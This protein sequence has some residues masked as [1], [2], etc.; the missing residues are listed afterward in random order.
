MLV[1]KPNKHHRKIIHL[2]KNQ[3]AGKFRLNGAEEQF[4]RCKMGFLCTP[5]S[6]FCHPAACIFL[7]KIIRKQI[8]IAT[9]I[10]SIPG[11]MNRFS[12]TNGKGYFLNYLTLQQM[13]RS[14]TRL[15]RLCFSS[16]RRPG[17]RYF[18][19]KKFQKPVND[20]QEKALFF[21]VFKDEA[22]SATG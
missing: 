18:T 21:L 19:Q 5:G 22:Y 10:S 4:D 7:S 11:S 9:K 12:F 20:L 3:L 17:I 8:K 2:L 16:R 13:V 14:K 6:S 15:S 1:Q